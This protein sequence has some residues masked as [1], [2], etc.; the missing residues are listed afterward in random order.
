MD[1]QQSSQV[2]AIVVHEKD[3]LMGWHAKHCDIGIWLGTEACWSVS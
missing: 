2:E 3:G 1:R